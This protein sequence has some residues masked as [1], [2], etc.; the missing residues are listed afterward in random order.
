MSSELALLRYDA[1]VVFLCELEGTVDEVA[2]DCH[3]FVVVACLIVLPS[4]VV[5]LGLWC[6]G[7]EDITEDILLARNLLEVFV[8]P[9]GIVAA[10]ADLVAFE[11]EELV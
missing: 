11:V 3:Q 4:E 10:G 5:V 8:E 6:V 2:I 7:C 1:V 9:N